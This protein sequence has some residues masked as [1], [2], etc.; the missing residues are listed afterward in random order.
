MAYGDPRFWP[1]HDQP[2]YRRHVAALAKLTVDLLV[3]GHEVVL[4]STDGPDKVSVAEL[5]AEVGP[6]L[7]PEQRAR[8]RAPEITGV[9]RLLE[10][11][12]SVEVVVSARFHGVLLAHVVGRPALAIA[13]ERKVSTLMDE[14]GQSRFCTPIDAFDAA[15]AGQSLG[16]LLA[17]RATLAADI[18][19]R[20][21]VYR[22]QV[23][24]QYDQL[25]RPWA[26]Q[27]TARAS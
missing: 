9:A 15:R 24:E 18:R 20:V 19:T 27:T 13:H 21:A 5:Q 3:A 25:L 12:G 22:R 16:E 6:S 23:D 1:K 10:I 8:L 14:M 26:A 4:F 11:L 7:S 17:T 2:L